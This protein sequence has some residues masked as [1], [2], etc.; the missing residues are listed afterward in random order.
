MKTRLFLCKGKKDMCRDNLDVK[1]TRIRLMIKAP[2]FGEP[3]YDEVSNLF[4]TCGICSR[5]MVDI[6]DVQKDGNYG[7]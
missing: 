7:D 5:D 2:E 1:D 4:S 3:L 6:D